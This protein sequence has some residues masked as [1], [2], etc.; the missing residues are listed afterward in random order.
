MNLRTLC[1]TNMVKQIK[2]LPP[3]LKE[4]IVDIS[5]K[6][7]KKDAIKKVT[8]DI[9]IVIKDLTDLLIDSHKNG[10]CFRR[11]KYTEDM[12]DIL[13]DTCLQVA[14]DFVRDYSECLLFNK[15]QY[16]SAGEDRYSSEDE[17]E[18]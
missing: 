16:S 13:F 7:F 4:E 1:Q 15:N 5:M 2:N 11:P 6:E 12:D 3:M 14:E 8:T 9:R 17:E 18:Y 10:N